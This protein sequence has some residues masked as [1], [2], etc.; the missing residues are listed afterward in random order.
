MSFAVG[1][2]R[3][4]GFVDPLDALRCAVDGLLDV[5]PATLSVSVKG[6]ELLRLRRQMDRLDAAFAARVLDANRNGVGLEDGHVSTTAWIGW[7][8]GL[9]PAQV[10]KVARQAELAELLPETGQA[11]REGRITTT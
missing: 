1:R 2:E 5:D 6:S 10:R 8:S 11:W 3:S 4:D 7:K 9:P